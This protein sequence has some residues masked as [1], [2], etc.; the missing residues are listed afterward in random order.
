M[1]KICS[2]CFI[3]FIITASYLISSG[4]N[5]E[6]II[7]LGKE[8]ALFENLGAFFLCL[9]SVLFAI[10]FFLSSGQHLGRFQTKKNYFYLL[11]AI[12]F[13]FG[14]G[15][16][17]SWGQRIIGWETPDLMQ[18]YNLQEETNIHNL[19]LFHSR[20][21]TGKR[22]SF[23]G[24]LLNFSRLFCIFWLLF[25]VAIPIINRSSSRINLYF[26][27]LGLPIV[28]LWLGTA[29]LSNYLVFH[30]VALKNFPHEVLSSLNEL[31]E[32]IYAFLFVLVAYFEAQKLRNNLPS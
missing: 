30:V 4:L 8:D 16:E 21:A 15:E 20:D 2:I 23:W 14:C 11:L 29:F 7:D 17:I 27:Q 32:S 5:S 31:K 9:A 12:M 6:T 22:K 28:F 13:L 3:Y 25:C 26:K 10:S 1:L 19:W 18:E 24:L